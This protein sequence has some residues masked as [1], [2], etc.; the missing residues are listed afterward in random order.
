VL[1]PQLVQ[2]AQRFLRE[3][4][5]AAPPADRL[6]VF[7]SPYYGWA[8]EQLSSAIRPDATAGE[9]PEVA[10]YESHRGPGSTADVDFW[11]SKEVR[12]VVHSH[13]NYAVADTKK[14]EEC[15]AYRLDTHPLVDAFVK[16]QSLGF[17]IPYLHNGEMHDYVPDFI[18]RLKTDP[19]MHLFLETKGFDP[20]GEVKRQAAVRWVNAVNAEGS[21][22]R[23][24]YAVAKKPGEVGRLVEE[25]GSTSLPDAQPRSQRTSADKTP[26]NTAVES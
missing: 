15:A 16:N 1:F 17:A 8:I 25:A 11:T 26:R 4:V 3:K 13:L 19:P 18:A 12:E 20:L 6:D 24:A 9:A 23:W 14:W 7:L 10:R 2:I 21:F 5:R 22:G